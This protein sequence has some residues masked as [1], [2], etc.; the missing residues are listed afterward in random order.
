MSREAKRKAGLF[1][2]QFGLLM[3]NSAAELA[4]VQESLHNPNDF[5]GPAWLG[6]ILKRSAGPKQITRY[7]LD[8]TLVTDV[9]YGA[10]EIHR[11]NGATCVYRGRK[12][13]AFNVRCKC[14]NYVWMPSRMIM[15]R[16]AC[17]IGCGS[18]GCIFSRSVVGWND[19]YQAVLY[20][21]RRLAAFNGGDE[22]VNEWGGGAYE[23]VESALLE[24]AAEEIVSTF[25]DR[26]LESFEWWMYRK[27]SWAPYGPGNVEWRA[28]IEDPFL[29]GIFTNAAIG[30]AS[31]EDLARALQV[32]VE[33]VRRHMASGISEDDL[34]DVLLEANDN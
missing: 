22:L 31:A 7:K 10:L 29:L 6:K 19:P 12:V 14:G 27:E 30:Q 16:W 20:Q 33:I 15:E 18:P 8:D 9:W 1:S 34:V 4:A 5:A 2:Q 13:Q 21:L 32:D 24:Q 25:T 11:V 3:R 17:G 26:Q 28:G 23:T